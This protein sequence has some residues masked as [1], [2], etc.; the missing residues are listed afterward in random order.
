MHTAI[1]KYGQPLTRTHRHRYTHKHLKHKHTDTRIDVRTHR[2]AGTQSQWDQTLP[3]RSWYIQTLAYTEGHI[4]PEID[5]HTGI[6]T[7]LRHKEPGVRRL[8]HA[9]PETQRHTV[10]SMLILEHTDER[11]QALGPTD[12]R[13][14][15]NTVTHRHFDSQ[16]VEQANTGIYI[17]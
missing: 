8:K 11:I 5:I 13:A 2:D 3:R 14:Y 17:H 9:K 4:E 10:S 16:I 1:R 12:T 15:K 6:H 7:P